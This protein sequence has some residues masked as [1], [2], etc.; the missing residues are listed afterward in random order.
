MVCP[1]LLAC[2]PVTYPQ[3]AKSADDDIVHRSGT[4]TIK[5]SAWNASEQD[6][7]NS[8]AGSEI[9]DEKSRDDTACLPADALGW[10]S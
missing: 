1:V 8:F 4:A 7:H 3:P 9:E 5:S 10:D 6:E 2:V